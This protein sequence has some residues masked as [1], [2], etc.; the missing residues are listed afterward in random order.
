MRRRTFA[1]IQNAR[2]RA[3][4]LRENGP[5]SAAHA[6]G[7]SEFL[8]DEPPADAARRQPLGD[9]RAHAFGKVAVGDEAYVWVNGTV[10]GLY[11]TCRHPG[12]D[13]ADANIADYIEHTNTVLTTIVRQ[14]QRLVG[15]RLSRLR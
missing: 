6:A 13:V 8:G 3:P 11:M 14:G 9:W 1:Q 7:G 4:R 2:G 5:A 10:D 12:T 15:R